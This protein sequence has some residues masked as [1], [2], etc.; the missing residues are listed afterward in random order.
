M[1]YP[2]LQDVAILFAFATIAII[3]CSKLRIPTIMGYLITG[4]L[5][6]PNCFRLIHNMGNISIMAEVGVVLLLFTIGLE[7]SLKQLIALKR[8][9]L[10]GGAL[11]V[12]LTVI[13]TAGVCIYLKIPANIAVFVGMLVSLSSTAIVLKILAERNEIDTPHGRATTG[14]LIFQDIAVIP[15]MLLAPMLVETTDSSFLPVL[16]TLGK[17]VVSVVVLFALARVVVPQL[18]RLVAQTGSNELFLLTTVLICMGVAFA[19]NR[20]GLSLALG[21]FLAGMVVSESG[22]GY[23]ALGNI[24]PFKDVFTGFFFISVGMMIV[25]ST[26]ITMPLQIFAGALAVIVIKSVVTGGIV[27]V[28]GYPLRTATLTGISLAQVGEF[29]FVLAGVGTSMGL[30][31]NTENMIFVAVS[32]LTM[33]A[34]PYLIKAGPKIASVL[35][36]LPLP[37]ILIRGYNKPSDMGKHEPKD[38]IIIVGYGVVGRN[39]ARVAKRL[40]IDYVIIE[41][42]PVTVEQEK[43]NGEHIIYGDASR[44]TIMEHAYVKSARLVVIT[45]PSSTITKRIVE[46]ARREA[47]TVAIIAR[48]RYVAELEPLRELGA[49]DVVVE[50]FEAAVGVVDRAMKR[51]Y[52]S[53]EDLLRY[54]AE[55]R[56][57]P[58][59]LTVSDSS[60]ANIS[61]LAGFD[62]SSA[63]VESVTVPVGSNFSGKTLRQ[64]DLG[65]RYGLILIAIKTGPLVKVAPGGEDRI[66]DRDELLLIG[67]REK[68]EFFARMLKS[69]EMTKP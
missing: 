39:L 26:F 44:D 29:S 45:I 65:F 24:T 16:F 15:M 5:V 59:E 66:A 6:G 13:A 17:V 33:A 21:A 53:A 37:G 42:N 60:P 22:Y 1:H 28:L 54:E 62:L 46:L 68:V 52:V 56:G 32:V 14:I 23:Q 58:Q 12:V 51:Y 40:D 55:I 2:I 61:A 7:F 9:A 67:E 63:A 4:L 11:Q 35:D 10:L 57:V 69:G 64:I 8:I 25:P 19:T 38:H 36:G 34:G 48:T 3:I 18:L 49:N 30:F 50:E 41:M 27:S 20:A 43:A 47:P 31:G